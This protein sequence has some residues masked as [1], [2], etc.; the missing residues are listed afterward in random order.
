MDANEG[1]KKK[2]KKTLDVR[3]K[4]CPEIKKRY[5]CGIC[6]M[7]FLEVNFCESKNCL[8]TSGFHRF[9]VIFVFL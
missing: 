8:K 1:A 3:Q 7:R 6:V 5:T 4:L 9:S 2:V